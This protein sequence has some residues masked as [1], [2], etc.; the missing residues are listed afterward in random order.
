MSDLYTYAVI[1]VISAVVFIVLGKNKSK[2]GINL[3]RVSCPVCHTRQPIIRMPNGIGQLLWGGT[4]CP[5][6]HTKLDKY[7]NVIS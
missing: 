6:C 7:G 2:F 5:K 1:A 4:V 3:K